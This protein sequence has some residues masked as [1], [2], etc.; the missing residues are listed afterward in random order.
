MICVVFDLN[1]KLIIILYILDKNSI[2]FMYELLSIKF[3]VNKFF[4]KVEW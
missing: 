1:K 2:L 4:I 3:S